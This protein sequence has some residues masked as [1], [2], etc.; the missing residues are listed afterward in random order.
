VVITFG[1]L[2]FQVSTLREAWGWDERDRAINTLPLHHVHG[3]VNLLLC[4]LASGACCEL[5]AKFNAEEIWE[6]LASGE[7]TVFMAV[8][9]I[10]SK[11]AQCWDKTEPTTRERWSSSAARLRLM[12]SGSAAL[13]LPLFE[14]WK[15]LTTHSLLERYGMTEIGMAISNP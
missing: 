3:V 10:Y 5:Y 8:P 2:E 11:L 13:P 12:V 9:T 14:K 7:V 15:D 6:R 1:N 4:S